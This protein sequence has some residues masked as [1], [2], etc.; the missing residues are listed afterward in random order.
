MNLLRVL[1]TW[2]SW[3]QYWPGEFLTQPAF[4]CGPDVWLHAVRKVATMA[5]RLAYVRRQR[6]LYKHSFTLHPEPE[7]HKARWLAFSF[8]CQCHCEG[9][10]NQHV[11]VVSMCTK[12]L[13]INVATKRATGSVHQDRT[14]TGVQKM[15]FSRSPVSRLSAVPFPNTRT[16]SLS[17]VPRPSAVP[18]YSDLQLFPSIRTFS[19]PQYSYLQPFPRTQIFSRSPIL[20]PSDVPQ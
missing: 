11:V 18:R 10:C 5:E 20:G 8:Q 7:C 1:I 9:L 15:T 2:N 12:L 17:P 4:R 3:K 14:L 13:I 19:F 16:S 6:A